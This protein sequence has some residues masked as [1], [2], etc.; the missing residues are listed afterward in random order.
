MSTR[1]GR[2][3]AVPETP[4]SCAMLRRAARRVTQRYD[5][6]LEPAGLRL[7]QYSILAN[8][9]AHGAMSISALAERLGMDRTTLSRTLRPL[10]EDGLVRLQ[11][12]ADRRAREVSLTAGGV[13]RLAAA[14]PL[15]QEAE[16][17]FRQSLGP[18]DS[19]TLRQ[20]LAR[21]AGG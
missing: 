20:L 6:A 8:L 18:A 13:E 9:D 2:K 7:T 14:R 21:A 12:G 5:G 1:V 16:R 11:G 15:W 17:A 4:C 10:K 19:A 3:A